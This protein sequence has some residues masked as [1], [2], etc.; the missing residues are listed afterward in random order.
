M[1]TFQEISVVVGFLYHQGLQPT[2]SGLQR[3]APSLDA[4]LLDVMQAFAP[5]VITTRTVSSLPQYSDAARGR[6]GATHGALA[7]TGTSYDAGKV[8][9]DDFPPETIVNLHAPCPGAGPTSWAMIWVCTPPWPWGPAH[10]DQCNGAQMESN[11]RP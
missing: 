8:A 1:E 5:G 10:W 3:L 11:A 2:L 4:D 7:E 9:V 6:L